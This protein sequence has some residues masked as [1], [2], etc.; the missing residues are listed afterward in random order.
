MDKSD[1]SRAIII[2]TTRTAADVSEALPQHLLL[3]FY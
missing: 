1:I 2:A 3:A